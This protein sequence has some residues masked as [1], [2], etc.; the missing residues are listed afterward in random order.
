M[1]YIK[2]KNMEIS[3]SVLG[4]TMMTNDN[5]VGSYNKAE[6]SERVAEDILDDDKIFIADFVNTVLLA[7]LQ[8]HGI[9][10]ADIR[11]EWDNASRL[12]IMDQWVIDSKLLE[13][14]YTFTVQ[15]L[16][17]TYGAPVLPPTKPNVSA[18]FQTLPFL[19][20]R[21]G[22]YTP[23]MQERIADVTTSIH[24][25]NVTAKSDKELAKAFEEML[26]DLH[27]GKIGR[28]EIHAAFSTALGVAYNAAIADGYGSMDYGNKDVRALSFLRK[29]LFLFSGAKSF[30]ELKDLR[31]LL[32]DES[33]NR[34][35]WN[36]FKK[37]AVAVNDEHNV[38]YLRTE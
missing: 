16:M 4:Q 10:G 25:N 20:A 7:F 29:N 35:G 11:F 27:D 19:P 24:Y 12:P 18:N 13:L 26:R 14:G 17:D 9:V 38:N 15:Y 30:E 1:K 23:S 31:G 37:A 22:A 36:D 3:K 21:E 28:N 8:K 6:V 34:R 32:I 2:M 5:G 33:G